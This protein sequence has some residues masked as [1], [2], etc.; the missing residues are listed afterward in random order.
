MV[1]HLIIFVS[2]ILSQRIFCF[3]WLEDL[4]FL[5]RMKA[6][7]SPTL[8]KKKRP[9]RQIVEKVLESVEGSY[10]SRLL[11]L[12]LL[13]IGLSDQNIDKEED[14]CGKEEIDHGRTIALEFEFA[15]QGI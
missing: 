7:L 1:F 10:L 9:L 2:S 4:C 6:V 3:R 15:V 8:S 13:E 11:L 5:I 14:D 12:S